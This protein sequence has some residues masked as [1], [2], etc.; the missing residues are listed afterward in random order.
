[1][2]TDPQVRKAVA[3]DRDYK[4]PDSGGLHLY[5]IKTGHRSWCLCQS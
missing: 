5:V 1:M 3:Q 2:L 4:L